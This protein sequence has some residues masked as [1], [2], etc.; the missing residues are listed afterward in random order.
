MMTIDCV[1]LSEQWE[2]SHDVRGGLSRRAEAL[3]YVD[4]A[5]LRGL[6]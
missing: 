3:G 6:E 5:R 1:N 4:E 2:R